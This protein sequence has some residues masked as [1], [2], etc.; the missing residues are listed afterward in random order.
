[1]CDIVKVLYMNIDKVGHSETKNVKLYSGLYWEAP[2][3]KGTFFRLEVYKRGRI[4]RVKVWKRLG[5][6]TFWFQ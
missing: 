2:P 1:M 4:S 3:E 6:Q 5:K